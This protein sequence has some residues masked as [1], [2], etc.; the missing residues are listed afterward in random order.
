MLANGGRP[1]TRSG[2]D[3]QPILAAPEPLDRGEFDAAELMRQHPPMLRSP[4]KVVVFRI[5]CPDGTADGHVSYSRWAQMP[6]PATVDSAAAASLLE[7]RD[8]FFD[9]EPASGSDS[10]VEWHVNFADPNL[11]YAYGSGLFAQDEMQVAEHP[12]L[13]SLREALVAEG[14]PR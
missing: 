14:D 13:G 5:A 2:G 10:M 1:V 6:L 11:F 12:V 7:V 4:N 9:Y 3:S 8:G